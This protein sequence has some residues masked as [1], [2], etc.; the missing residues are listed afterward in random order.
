MYA[1]ACVNAVRAQSTL[2]CSQSHQSSKV[3]G[4]AQGRQAGVTQK[5]SRRD[6]DH[7]EGSAPA[8]KSKKVRFT[9]LPKDAGS[10]RHSLRSAPVPQQHPT[11]SHPRSSSRAPA[12]S[13]SRSRRKEPTSSAPDQ[14]RQYSPRNAQDS[15]AGEGFQTARK[16]GV[17]A[18]TRAAVRAQTTA[19]QQESTT[20]APHEADQCFDICKQPNAASRSKGA[21]KGATKTSTSTCTCQNEKQRRANAAHQAGECAG[22]HAPEPT[23]SSHTARQEPAAA[24]T[25]T[26]SRAAAV[27]TGRSK[28]KEHSI[29]D[30]DEEVRCPAA[31]RAQ[32]NKVGADVPTTG[33]T[34]PCPGTANALT[35][36]K[37]GRPVKSNQQ[38]ARAESGLAKDCLAGL[39]QMR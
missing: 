2:A 20:S 19:H 21:A 10:I 14:E 25:R 11:V 22:A 15:A 24:R 3:N 18:R 7:C 1:S 6:Q 28:R 23:Q 27:T 29:A 32:A 39:S 8:I 17:A 35:K 34:A 16:P 33:S 37:A 26:A 30:S 31:K 12:G 4:K 9:E 38:P 13:H 36:Q 5:R